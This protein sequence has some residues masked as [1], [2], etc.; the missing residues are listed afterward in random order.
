MHLV[1]LGQ[2]SATTLQDAPH[3]STSVASSQTQGLHAKS[4]LK[5]DSSRL[6]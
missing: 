3:T 5:D 6:R 1:R 2:A 4:L